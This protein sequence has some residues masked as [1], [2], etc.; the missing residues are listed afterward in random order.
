[1]NEKLVTSID[2]VGR[3][4]NRC[5]GISDELASLLEIALHVSIKPAD[6]DNLLAAAKRTNESLNLMLNNL[7][8]E[9]SEV[10]CQA[11]NAAGVR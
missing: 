4:I 3:G 6:R 1:M 2:A 7:D 11:E 9:S 10:L 5:V 8:V